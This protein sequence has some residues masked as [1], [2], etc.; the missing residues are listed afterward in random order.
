MI[1]IIQ[2]DGLFCPTFT[3]DIC[4]EKVEHIDGKPS[5]RFAYDGD[6]D[7]GTPIILCGPA[8]HHVADHRSGKRLLWMPLSHMVVNLWVNLELDVNEFRKHAESLRNMP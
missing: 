6:L 2:K 1:N 3:C 8:C 5:P 4:G 7:D